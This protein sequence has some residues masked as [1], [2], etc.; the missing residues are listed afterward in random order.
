MIWIAMKR[1]PSPFARVMSAHICA[2]LAGYQYGYQ[3]TDFMG[4]DIFKGNNAA[5]AGSDMNHKYQEGVS[6]AM[7]CNVVY[8]S[9]QF[10]YGLVN[11]RISAWLTMRWVFVISMFA[12]WIVY[13]CFFFVDSKWAYFGLS[14]PQGIINCVM[15]AT[16]YAIVTLCIPTEDLGG[17]LGLTVCGTMIGQQLSNFMIGTGLGYAW[18]DEPRLLLGISCVFA[19]LAAF[20]G[21]VIVTPGNDAILQYQSYEKLDD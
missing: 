19:L 9:S 18:P 12:L 16:P 5:S 20:L 14:V 8:Y 2:Q 13:G 4:K 6:W 1:M 7:M 17:N 11:T 21:F 3:F 15:N 10:L